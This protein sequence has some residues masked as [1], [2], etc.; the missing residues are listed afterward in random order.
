MAT[1]DADIAAVRNAIFGRDVR[2]A[3]ADALSQMNNLVDSDIL[4]YANRN[5]FPDE[6]IIGKLYLDCAENVFYRW[7]GVTYAEISRIGAIPNIE[8]IGHKL[9]IS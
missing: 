9:V 3:I 7:N 8:V 2:Q 1:I 4:Q 5:A 6:G